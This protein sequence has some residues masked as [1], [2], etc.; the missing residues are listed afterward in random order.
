MSNLFYSKVI[1]DGTYQYRHV[2][3]PKGTLKRF[4]AMDHFLTDLELRTLGI[5]QQTLCRNCTPSAHHWH[6]YAWHAPEP[7]LLMFRRANR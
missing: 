6:H 7:D 2:I 1:D 3:C 4:R 5:S